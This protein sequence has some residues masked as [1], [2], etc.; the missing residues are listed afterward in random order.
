MVTII[1]GVTGGLTAAFLK[2][3]IMCSYSKKNR[4]DVGAMANG[5]LAGLVSITGV[6][7]RCEPWTAFVIG[8]IGGLVYSLSCKLM[9]ALNIDDP[10]EAA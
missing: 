4:Y 5:L 8:L 10:I 3:L 1:S 9:N 7:D 6:C 2:P